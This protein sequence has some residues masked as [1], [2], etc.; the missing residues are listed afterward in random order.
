[1]KKVVKKERL[2]YFEI[3]TNVG[4]VAH[5]GYAKSKSE[6]FLSMSNFS[7]NNLDLRNLDLR[8]LKLN[9]DMINCNF[10]GAKLPNFQ[11]PQ[12]KEITVYKKAKHE[13]SQ[14]LVTMII[15]KE[16]RRTGCLFPNKKCRAE[17]AIITKIERIIWDYD[18]GK[19]VAVE[20]NQKIVYSGWLG[21]RFPYELGKKVFPDGYNG[22]IGVECTNGIHFFMKK[23]DA[24]EYTL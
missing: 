9:E 2:R 10:K 12:N 3:L 5:A 20:S 22:D 14:Y 8:K 4:S 19:P 7:R 21:Y 15:P 17:F 1:M 16:A 11:V 6:L 18:R 23:K 24:L 13:G